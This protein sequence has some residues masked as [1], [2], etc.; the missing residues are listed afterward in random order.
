VHFQQVTAA[1]TALPVLFCGFAV[2]SGTAQDIL[3]LTAC[4]TWHKAMQFLGDRE[5]CKNVAA[6]GHSFGGAQASLFAACANK[7]AGKIFGTRDDFQLITFG[8]FAPSVGELY[9]GRPGVHFKGTRYAITES[10]FTNPL[11]ALDPTKIKQFRI[12]ILNYFALLLPALGHA[13]VVPYITNKIAEYQDPNFTVDDVNADWPFVEVNIAPF[14]LSL[15]TVAMGGAGLD[16]LQN[17][18]LTMVTQFTAQGLLSFEYDNTVASASQPFAYNHALVKFQPLPNPL[19][20][21]K[22]TAYRAVEAAQAVLLPR[23]DFAQA[24]FAT[25][26]SFGAGAF[27]PNHNICCYS[28]CPKCD[29]KFNVTVT[30]EC[31]NTVYR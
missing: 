4:R 25:I 7:G 18:L 21:R 2:H 13:P 14:F 6:I 30:K 10:D 16:A 20:T 31:H 27:F 17:A 28:T 11:A 26:G 24:R 12:D 22:G 9:N 3:S 8:A 5:T 23:N 15:G 29:E 19:K 1:L